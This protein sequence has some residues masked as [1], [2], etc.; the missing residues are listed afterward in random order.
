MSI[1][2]LAL[3]FC[4]R[5][6]R[7]GYRRDVRHASSADALNLAWTGIALRC[8]TVARDIGFAARS[9]VKAPLFTI[10]ALV[11]LALAISVNAVAFGA[12][13]AILLKPLPFVDPSQLVFL[14]SPYSCDQTDG[15][16][17]QVFQRESK[18]LQDVAGFQY[19]PTT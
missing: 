12:I 18:T 6:F 9:L 4:P 7:D 8:E 10:V 5:E 13:N 11:T 2:D 17:M 16:F 14:C 15:S 1:V 19:I 3:L